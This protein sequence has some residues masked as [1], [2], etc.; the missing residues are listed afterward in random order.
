MPDGPPQTDQPVVGEGFVGAAGPD[1]EGQGPGFMAGEGEE[2]GGG[3]FD[4]KPTTDELMTGAEYLESGRSVY[5]YGEKVGDV[6]TYPAFPERRAV[7]A[8]AV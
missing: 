7:G 5:S 1:D 4:R 6:T 3:P 8:A 2:P